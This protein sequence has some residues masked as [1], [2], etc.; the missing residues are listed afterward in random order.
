MGGCSAVSK[1]RGWN[2]EERVFVNRW[3]NPTEKGR[4]ALSGLKLSGGSCK[5]NTCEF[6]SQAVSRLELNQ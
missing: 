6:Q 4:A 3:R 5:V 2:G 1:V